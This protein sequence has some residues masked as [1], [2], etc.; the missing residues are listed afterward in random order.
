MIYHICSQKDWE[1]A[2]KTG[3]YQPESLQKEGFIHFST[4]SQISGTANL[5]YRGVHDLLLLEIDETATEQVHFEKPAEDRPG[6]FPHCYG[7]LP[8]SAVLRVIPFEPQKDGSFVLPALLT[9]I[10]P[11]TPER[12]KFIYEILYAAL[13]AVNPEQV[14]KDAVIATPLSLEIQGQKFDLSHIANIFVVSLGKAAMKMAKALDDILGARITKGIVVTKHIPDHSSVNKQKYQVYAGGHPVPDENSVLAAKAVLELVASSKQSDLVIFLISG[15]GSALMTYPEDDISLEDF[16]NMTK[17]LLASGA[18]IHEMNVLRKHLDRVKGGKLS[19]AANPAQTITCIL[20]DVV[21]NSLESIASGPTVSDPSTYADCLTILDKYQL[22][23]KIPLS[24]RDWLEKGFNKE[25]PETLKPEDPVA[26]R[27]SSFLIG[28][29]ARAAKAAVKKAQ[30]AGWSTEEIEEPI[31]GEAKI[32]G[33]ELAKK[34]MQ[35]VP[36]R[37]RLL[38]GGGET[39]VK[40]KGNGL[41]G[42]NLETALA[43]VKMLDDIKHAALVTLATDGED[44]PTDAAGAIVTGDTYHNGL[45]K[46][47]DPDQYLERNDSYHYFEQTGGLIRIGSTGTNVNDLN[48]LFYF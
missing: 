15:G 41:G 9:G 18:D 23:A 32:A 21:G 20:S 43:A 37:P 8:V 29:N 40:I 26:K 16:Q 42:R 24:I 5:F 17:L 13:D 11:A 22:T 2:Q 10:F 12:Q 48:F 3:S 25:V 47:L 38:V 36:L 46:G 7:S 27:I 6:I 45:V 35:P 31:I 19:L 34:I 39:T 28:D 1:I 30:E 14:V 4:L 33:V 44:G